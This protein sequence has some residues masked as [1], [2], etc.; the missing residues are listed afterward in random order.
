M[1]D[2]A[3]RGATK[4]KHAAPK[5]KYVDPIVSSTFAQDGSF[6]EICRALAVKLKDPNSTV[7][8]LFI[9]ETTILCNSTGRL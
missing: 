8:V 4:P 6:H 3:V 1:A 5:A 9:Y 2:K 7:I